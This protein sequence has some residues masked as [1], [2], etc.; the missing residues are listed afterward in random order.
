MA[1]KAGTMNAVRAAALAAVALIFLGA[2]GDDSPPP[3]AATTSTDCYPT[4]DTT[5]VP[6]V[7]IV[8]DIAEGTSAES[9]IAAGALVEDEADWGLRPHTSFESL[10]DMAGGVAVADLPAN[11][12]A[13]VSQW[14]LPTD[15]TV[16]TTPRPHCPR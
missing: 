14:G 7:V 12:A 2:C 8:E 5:Q 16:A 10:E 4:I 6:I 1:F 9:A 15:M 3:E 13:L 11:Q